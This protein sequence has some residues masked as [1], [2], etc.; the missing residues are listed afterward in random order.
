VGRGLG[1]GAGAT[2]ASDESPNR[3]CSCFALGSA[4]S[5]AFDPSEAI[6]LELRDQL[7]LCRF[8]IGDQKLLKD[9]IRDFELGERTAE[10][11]TDEEQMQ[12]V[13]R[14]PRDKALMKLIERLLLPGGE[15]ITGHQSAW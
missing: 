9:R 13:I 1:N 7:A 15:L 4:L 8:W 11:S 5:I 2:P 6:R 3:L 14:Q 10:G 12:L